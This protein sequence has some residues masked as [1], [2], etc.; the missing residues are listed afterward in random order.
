MGLTYTL[1]LTRPSSAAPLYS[2]HCCCY[3]FTARQKLQACLRSWVLC[4][5]VWHCVCHPVHVSDMCKLPVCMMFTLGCAVLCCVWPEV[6]TQSKR[7]AGTGLLSRT[8]LDMGCGSWTVPVG[9]EEYG[10]AQISSWGSTS[11]SDCFCASGFGFNITDEPRTCEP[12]PLGTFSLARA[13][14]EPSYGTY[15]QE[16]IVPVAKLSYSD[17]DNSRVGDAS[18]CMVLIITLEFDGFARSVLR[19]WLE[20]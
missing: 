8:V 4:G 20:E 17:H 14:E 2:A 12:C 16:G 3:R 1:K 10:Q 9:C 18:R 13:E 6:Y 5:T 11:R 15:A 19:S 7:P